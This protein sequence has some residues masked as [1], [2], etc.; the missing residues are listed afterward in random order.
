MVINLSVFKHFQF[1]AAVESQDQQE[2]HV[3]VVGIGKP[4]LLYMLSSVHHPRK[5]KQSKFLKRMELINLRYEK[6][7]R[8][9]FVLQ[10]QK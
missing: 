1:Q 10:Q 9:L 3:L 4:L 8:G 2:T 6:T 5:Q 7:V